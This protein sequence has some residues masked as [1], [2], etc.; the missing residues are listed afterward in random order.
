MSLEILVEI[1]VV[2]TE[3]QAWEFAQ[4]L[5]RSGFSDYR[6]CATSEAELYHMID[7]GEHLRRALAEQG[8][9]PR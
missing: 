9:A 3:A 8:Y 7:A 6:T 2:L 1:H 5:K 4:L